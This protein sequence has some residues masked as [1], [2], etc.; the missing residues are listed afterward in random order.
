MKRSRKLDVQTLDLFAEPA[1]SVPDTLTALQRLADAG[2]LRRLD[3]ALAAMVAD[4]DAGATPA[5]L[6]ATAVL[7]QME[8][9]GHSCLPLTA[10]AANPNAVLA[11]PSEALAAQQALWAQLP[12]SWADW[13][14][15]LRRSPVVRVLGRDADL[16]QPLVLR[17][18]GAP[19]LYLRRYWD[20]ERS[21]AA[22]IAARTTADVLLDEAKVRHWLQR[23]FVPANGIAANA[24][25]DWQKLACALALRGRMSVITGGPGTGKTYTAARLLAL[26]FA[27]APDAT[28]LRIALAAP[29]GKA[30]ARLKQSIDASLLQLQD[31]VQPE[32][33]LPSLVQ[34]MGAAR[35]LHALLGARP[36][37]RHFKHHAGQ[38]LD[39]DVLIVDEASMIHLEMMAAL[40]EALPPTA[41]LILLGD[42]DQ[43]ASVEAGAVLGDL[44]SNAQAGN[45]LADTAAY[46]QRVTGQAIPAEFMAESRGTVDGSPA[47]ETGTAQARAPRKGRLVPRE[48]LVPSPSGE[49]REGED[50]Q[51]LRG[52]TPIS[53]HMV[54]LRESRRFSGPIGLL[55]LAVNAGD[56]VAAQALLTE[57]TRAG[58]DAA[59][60]AH[61]GGPAQ[62]VARMAVQGRGPQP[63]YRL[64]AQQLQRGLLARP[65][66]AEAHAAWVQTVL[67]A[68]DR[69]RLLCAVREGDWGVA[70]LNTAVVKELRDAGLV[71]AEG[72][73][74]AG[75]PVM[76]TRNDAQLEVFN[77]DIGMVLPSFA[78]PARLR[79]YFLRGDGLHHVSTARLAQ[80]ETAFAMTVHKSQGSEFAHT[81]L[82]LAAQGGNVLGRELVYT[83]ITRAR[84]AFTLWTEVPGLLASAIGSPTQRSSGL[85]RF[86]EHPVKNK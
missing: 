2:L 86:W 71:A 31:I 40:L 12:A 68:F 51:R 41:R 24:S 60:W 21:V 81:A 3:S 23:L 11:W 38:P 54:M 34:R 74:Y 25:M 20:Y 29:T 58:R 1:L 26:L 18:D 52:S 22:Q 47:S 6:V 8:G 7:A 19:L 84:E 5:L 82:V 27:T 70:G 62:Q 79:V 33:D 78:D 32:L 61:Q 56:A 9:R 37:T 67:Q 75:R 77:G 55:A 42:K 28:Q 48:A 30:A 76:V 57:H 44:C 46:A 59:L 14:E 13:Q 85:L 4:Q 83:G 10:L 66:T 35:T 53:Q 36:D 65:A 73:W 17:G 43:L 50:A 64:Y 69:F 72:E 80:V 45:Y 16:G 39:V 49:A 63:G 15:A